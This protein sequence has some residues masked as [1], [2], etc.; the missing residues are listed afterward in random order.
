[1]RG[2]VDDQC[3]AAVMVHRFKLRGWDE[4]Q[5][6]LA[7]VTCFV[8]RTDDPEEEVKVR[9]SAGDVAPLARV[10]HSGAPQQGV[11]YMDLV[12]YFFDSLLESFHSPDTI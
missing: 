6:V 8:T 1:M 5:E 2:C 11:D 7:A 4:E 12:S 9:M 3:R 10:D